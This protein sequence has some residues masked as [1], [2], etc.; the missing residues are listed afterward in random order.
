VVSAAGAGVVASAAK[1]VVVAGL[2]APVAA[3]LAGLGGPVA[4]VR[5]VVVAAARVAS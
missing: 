3:A 1:A 2:G 4:V 5:V